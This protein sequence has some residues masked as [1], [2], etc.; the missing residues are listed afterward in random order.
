MQI[1]LYEFGKVNIS[2]RTYTSDILISGGVICDWWRKEGH[3]LQ[4]P[5]LDEIWKHAPSVLIV[6]TGV[7]G[8]MK[9]SDEV[10]QKCRQKGVELKVCNTPGA[11][12][13][14]NCISDSKNSACGL[15]LTC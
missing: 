9:V 11:V 1:E 14:F 4:V 5:D 6:G 15:H 7:S 10:E 2:G 13:E 12:K 3:L 8:V